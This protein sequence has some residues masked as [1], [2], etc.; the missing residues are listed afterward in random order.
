[1]KRLLPVLA[2]LFFATPLAAQMSFGGR[3]GMTLSRFSTADDEVEVSSI[4]GMHASAAVTLMRGPAGLLLSGGYSERG[5]GFAAEGLGDLDFRFR[6]AYV[7]VAA[8]GKVPA[9]GGAYL[10]A[11][12]T[13]GLRVS[14][15]ATVAG[16][17]GSQSVDCD[18]AGDDPFRVYDFGVAGGAGFAF[19]AIDFHMV[20]EVL[21]GF[22]FVNISDVDNDTARNRG[23]T[24]R[25]GLD[26]G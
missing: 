22:G 16:G 17:L 6:L 23:L 12:P 14:C 24:L 1:M 9:A 7:E 26:L 11:G 19:D 3:A 18:E 13:A 8:L 21:Y 15:T 2:T 5:T 25:V 10:L 4:A 20:V